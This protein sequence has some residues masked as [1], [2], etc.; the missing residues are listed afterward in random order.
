MPCQSRLGRSFR[1]FTLVE[2]LVVI[3]II[4]ILAGLILPA[5]MGVRERGK[6]MYCQNNLKQFGIALNTYC[7]LYDGHFPD[8]HDGQ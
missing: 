2:M 4:G 1:A 6:S 5:L 3:A 7:I 8:I